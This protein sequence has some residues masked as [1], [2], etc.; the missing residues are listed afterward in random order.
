MDDALGRHLV[1]DR[2][3][4]AQ[5]GLRAVQVLGVE[6]RADRLQGGAQPRPHLAVVLAA[7]DVLP[8][9]LQG[10]LCTLGHSAWVLSLVKIPV[11]TKGLL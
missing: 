4:G 6:R 8:I 7:D 10:G 11:L 5:R 2:D 9:R 3:R 1:D